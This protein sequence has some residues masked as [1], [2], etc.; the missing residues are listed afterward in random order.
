VLEQLV[1]MAEDET[2]PSLGSTEQQQKKRRLN[3]ALAVY[4]RGKEINTRAIKDKKIRRNL[5]VIEDKYQKAALRAKDAE[6]LLEQPGFLE[7]ETELERTYK[8]RQDD[9]VKNV[10]LDTAQKRFELNLDQLGP[11][12]ADYTRNGRYLALAGRKGHVATM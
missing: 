2:R 11:Y 8:V 3:E 9:I 4:G 6:I 5:R 12:V 10:N 1:R 7:A